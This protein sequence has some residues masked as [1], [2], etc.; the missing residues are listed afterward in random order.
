MRV[1][2]LE[3]L[4]KR[5][6][7]SARVSKLRGHK[8]LLLEAILATTCRLP[9]GHEATAEGRK[10]KFLVMVYMDPGMLRTIFIPHGVFIYTCQYISFI[11]LFFRLNF[12]SLPPSVILI[13][14]DLFLHQ[15]EALYILVRMWLLSVERAVSLWAPLGTVAAPNCVGWGQRDMGHFR[16]SSWVG[17]M[18]LVLK[19][20]WHS[21]C[22]VFAL[23][24]YLGWHGGT[25]CYLWLTASFHSPGT[26]LLCLFLSIGQK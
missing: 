14:T 10:S 12:C 4:R 15:S 18:G 17:G 5:H 11:A 2:L 23:R 13:E 16:S 26:W 21:S 20:C 8:L 22:T 25:L 7:V 24:V 1:H 9:A 6:I 19:L 3:P